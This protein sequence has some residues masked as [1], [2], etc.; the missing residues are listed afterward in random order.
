MVG[1]KGSRGRKNDKLNLKL[2]DLL[3]KHRILYVLCFI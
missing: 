1:E 3:S 2:G